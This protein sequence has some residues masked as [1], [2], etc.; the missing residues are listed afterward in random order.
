V[1]SKHPEALADGS[2][3]QFHHS[4]KFPET[5]TTSSP[6]RDSDT[7]NR[8]ERIMRTHPKHRKSTVRQIIDYIYILNIALASSAIFIIAATILRAYGRAAS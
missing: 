3:A 1:N 8:Q 4:G 5:C 7:S 6:I 2:G